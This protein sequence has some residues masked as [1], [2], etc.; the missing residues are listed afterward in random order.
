M[1]SRTDA[2][3][4]DDGS[5]SGCRLAFVGAG[6]MAEAMIAGILSR[7]VVVPTQIV[8]SHPRGVRGLGVIDR[9]GITAV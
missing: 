9:F 2:S 6:V 3:Q 8:A 4:S 7:R 5:L 1:I